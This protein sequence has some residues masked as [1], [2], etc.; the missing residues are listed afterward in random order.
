[1]SSSSNDHDDQNKTCYHG[2]LNL[3]NFHMNDQRLFRYR[4]TTIGNIIQSDWRGS[5]ISSEPKNNAAD[6]D[7][8]EICRQNLIA[9]LALIVQFYIHSRHM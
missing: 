2:T 9:D 4:Q 5:C 3:L 8:G 6:R 1:M 7:S